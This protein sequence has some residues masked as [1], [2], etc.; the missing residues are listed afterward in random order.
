LG[1]ANSVATVSAAVL[2]R[3][4]RA[5]HLQAQIGPSLP[6]LS[7]LSLRSQPNSSSPSLIATAPPHEERA[8]SRTPCWRLVQRLECFAIPEK[9]AIERIA[10]LGYG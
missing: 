7:E 1:G 10:A 6:Q 3:R 9:R 4:P 2:S 5:R 8:A